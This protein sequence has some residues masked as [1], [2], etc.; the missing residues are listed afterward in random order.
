MIDF[1]EMRWRGIVRLLKYEY[2]LQ[3]LLGDM[4]S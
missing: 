1:S 3:Y 4:S 2:D